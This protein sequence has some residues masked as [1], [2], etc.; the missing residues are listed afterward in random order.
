MYNLKKVLE[1]YSFDLVQYVTLRYALEHA[2]IKELTRRQQF[3]LRIPPVFWGD[4]VS[5]IV[6]LGEIEIFKIIWVKINGDIH[7]PKYHKLLDISVYFYKWEMTLHLLQ[8]GAN[9]NT[10]DHLGRTP[11]HTFCCKKAVA[12]WHYD[13]DV[14]H[15]FLE[16]QAN[17]DIPDGNGDTPL[18]LALQCDNDHVSSII[19]AAKFT[20]Y[21]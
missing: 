2:T 1:H 16:Y 5:V 11:F 6:C 19:M 21:Q 20:S 10:Q 12:Q 18:D 17:P 15:R 9:P 13:F 14:I 7:D 3:K 8:I 4:P